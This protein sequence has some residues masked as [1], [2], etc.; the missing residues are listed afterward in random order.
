MDIIFLKTAFS[1]FPN[2]SQP[3]KISFLIQGYFLA[4]AT[5][6]SFSPW[7]VPHYLTSLP[8]IVSFSSTHPCGP[9]QTIILRLVGDLA[10]LQ[11][12]TYDF[13]LRKLYESMQSMVLINHFP[14]R[15]SSEYNLPLH[16]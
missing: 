8:Q 9:L 1:L 6:A 14:Q 11:S 13:H 10:V 7:A 3:I 16:L 12:Y 4:H 2:I 15:I 5:I